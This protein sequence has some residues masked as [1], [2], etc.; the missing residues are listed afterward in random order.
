[1][2]TNLFVALVV[3]LGPSVIISQSNYGYRPMARGGHFISN[4]RYQNQAPQQQ[5][6]P[7]QFPVSNYNNNQQSAN[8]IVGNTALNTYGSGAVNS[9]IGSRIS[10][11]DLAV[12]SIINPSSRSS[13][14]IIG[15]TASNTH[16]GRNN[17]YGGS[18]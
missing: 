3:L 17:F 13:N 1:M 8:N 2:L 18:P 5:Y 14:N 11:S 12:N 16:S 9:I 10:D 6:N 4:G 15:N 7:Y